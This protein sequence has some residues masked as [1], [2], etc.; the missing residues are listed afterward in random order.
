[1]KSSDKYKGESFQQFFLLP[2]GLTGR[3]PP[4]R[5]LG[6]T[7]KCWVLDAATSI[8]EASDR[9]VIGPAF[10]LFLHGLGQHRTIDVRVLW[11]LPCKLPVEVGSVSRIKL[12]TLAYC[13]N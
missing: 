9:S 3:A 12:H 8:A 11:C 10:K 2:T 6:N 1:M 4:S 13:L 5:L 7:A